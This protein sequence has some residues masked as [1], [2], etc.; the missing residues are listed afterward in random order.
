MT[1]KKITSAKLSPERLKEL[2]GWTGAPNRLE[3]EMAVA[4]E[5]PFSY[6][7]LDA[8]LTRY[9]NLIGPQDLHM[10][11]VAGRIAYR[12]VGPLFDRRFADKLS[13]GCEGAVDGAHAKEQCDALH[14]TVEYNAEGP[15]T[16]TVAKGVG[17]TAG[18]LA[19]TWLVFGPGM[20]LWHHISEKM[21]GPKGPGGPAGGAPSTGIPGTTPSSEATSHAAERTAEV[22]SDAVAKMGTVALILGATALALID[23]PL[24]FGDA[25]AACLLAGGGITLGTSVPSTPKAPDQ[26]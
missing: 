14:E 4:S 8:L 16:K 7:Q 19:G 23:G 26:L 22:S 5:H 11:N 10:T 21:K 2:E 20:S 18:G 15:M 17:Y 6:E 13:E 9:D 24:L 1:E 3:G 12:S 25:A